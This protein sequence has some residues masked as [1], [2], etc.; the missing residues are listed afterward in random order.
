MDLL[1]EALHDGVKLTEEELRNEVDTFMFAVHK[2]SYN[3][4]QY[5]S[6][7]SQ[8]I[9]V[10]LVTSPRDIQARIESWVSD[11]GSRAYRPDLRNTQIYVHLVQGVKSEDMELKLNSISCP[12]QEWVATCLHQ[13][14]HHYLFQMKP[15]RCTLLLTT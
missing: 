15:T 11:K 1:L 12:C 4:Y 7:S 14:S 13:I 5:S 2:F 3:L 9:S 6:N 10:S 8:C